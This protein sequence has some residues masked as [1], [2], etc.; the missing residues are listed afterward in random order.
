MKGEPVAPEI[1]HALL[2]EIIHELD[3]ELGFDSWHCD[4]D[5]WPEES[6]QSMPVLYASSTAFLAAKIYE[7]A[8]LVEGYRE[9]EDLIRE[10]VERIYRFVFGK[11][12]IPRAPDG[13][14]DYKFAQP[15]FADMREE[16]QKGLSGRQLKVFSLIESVCVASWEEFKADF[17]KDILDTRGPKKEIDF[18]WLSRFSFEKRR[19]EEIVK[20]RLNM[21]LDG[22]VSIDCHEKSFIQCVDIEKAIDILEAKSVELRR[23]GLE[24]GISRW[25]VEEHRSHWA[26]EVILKLQIATWRRQDFLDFTTRFRDAHAIIDRYVSTSFADAPA[27]DDLM[28]ICESD[29]KDIQEPF[30]EAL[31]ALF[32]QLHEIAKARMAG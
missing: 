16:E 22:H 25:V 2:G 1:N 30:A 26:K 8:C 14:I 7:K 10:Y 18:H 29:Q 12:N 11:D 28:S 21:I 27:F 20:F 13:R 9:K 4:E 6:F 31:E 32:E 23:E 19:H 24:G 3:K 5:M 15:Y 17:A